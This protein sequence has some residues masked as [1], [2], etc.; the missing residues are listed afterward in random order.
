MSMK[1]ASLLL[2]TTNQWNLFLGLMF[3]LGGK[4]VQLLSVLF[5]FTGTIQWLYQDRQSN[6]GS[7]LLTHY[8]AGKL[9][10]CQRLSSLYLLTIFHLI[11]HFT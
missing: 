5:V 2:V 9:E 10:Y 1:S 6:Q 8:P 7:P 3:F 4:L 11:F